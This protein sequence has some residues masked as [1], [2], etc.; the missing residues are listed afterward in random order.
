MASPLFPNTLYKHK[1]LA[2]D[3]HLTQEE[4]NQVGVE[5]E[6]V[7]SFYQIVWTACVIG[8]DT[9]YTSPTTANI[10]G[11]MIPRTVLD[12]R[13]PGGRWYA[14]AYFWASAPTGITATWNLNYQKDDASMVVLGSQTYPPVMASAKRSIAAVEFTSLIE[15]IICVR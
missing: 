11:L 5:V 14:S 8:A 1:G 15:T 9:T 10:G 2:A 12:A 13:M 7:Q 6:A 4:W 3:Q